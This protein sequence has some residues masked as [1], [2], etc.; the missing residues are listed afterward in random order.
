MYRMYRALF[1]GGVG[2]GIGKGLI[3][4]EEASPSFPLFQK[5]LIFGRP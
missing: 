2:G 1:R 4:E 3:L 5:R